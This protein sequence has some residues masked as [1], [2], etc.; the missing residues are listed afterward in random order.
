VKTK[1]TYSPDELRAALGIGRGSVYDLLRSGQLRSV[2]VGRRIVVPISEVERFLAG[3][4]NAN[5]AMEAV[6]GVG[7][8]PTM[9]VLT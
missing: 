3:I 2:R 6:N 4:P 1:L 7:V 5:C 8:A 9:K